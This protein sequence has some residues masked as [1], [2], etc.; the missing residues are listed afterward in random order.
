MLLLRA[1]ANANIRSE[2]KQTGPNEPTNVIAVIPKGHW[3]A[4]FDVTNDWMD[5]TTIYEG[6]ELKGFI[7]KS[8][9]EIQS[10]VPDAAQ[11]EQKNKFGRRR[12][13]FYDEQAEKLRPFL[14]IDPPQKKAKPVEVATFKRSRE[15]EISWDYILSGKF[16][17]DYTNSDLADVFDASS[18]LTYFRRYFSWLW[19][20]TA[21]NYD[22][23]KAALHQ[24]GTY[25]LPRVTEDPATPGSVKYE[26]VTQVDAIV[27]THPTASRFYLL[28]PK[29][30]KTITTND[31]DTFA[32][33]L[34]MWSDKVQGIEICYAEAEASTADAILTSTAEIDLAPSIIIRQYDELKSLA[35]C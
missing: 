17:S 6:K 24:T 29:S 12:D 22:A 21:T 5:G 35:G 13:V 31:F 23:K 28:K 10:I 20:L 26:M 15:V 11:A 4:S 1:T 27:L 25:K 3:F 14:S 34:S 16:V 8:L 18:Q 19:N 9:L 32:T 2:P 33:Y 30:S 7:H